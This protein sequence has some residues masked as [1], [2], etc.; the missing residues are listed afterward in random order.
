MGPVRTPPERRA[1]C[2]FL[3][4]RTVKESEVVTRDL[5]VEA[6]YIRHVCTRQNLH[7]WNSYFT[8]TSILP[9]FSI[10]VSL[11]SLVLMLFKILHRHKYKG[12]WDI[13]GNLN[14]DYVK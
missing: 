12:H 11:S 8:A 4:A 9:F 7:F 5:G 6:N 14:S 3:W 2:L 13:W 1:L 10:V